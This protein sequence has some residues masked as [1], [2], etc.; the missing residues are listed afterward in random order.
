VAPVALVFAVLG[1][2]VFGLASPGEAAGVGALGALLPAGLR[3][4]L[5]LKILREML[6]MAL[7]IRRFE[8]RPREMLLAGEIR[9]TAHSSIGQEATAVGARRALEPRDLLLAHHRGHGHTLTRG[10]EPERMFAELPGRATGCCGGLG[11]SMHIADLSRNILGANGIVS[12]GTGMGTGAAPAAQL[13]GDGS[14]EVAFFGDG[15]ANEGIFHEAM[16]LAAIWRLPLILFCENNR[17][18]LSTASDAVTAGPGVARR[19]AGYG[20]PVHRTDGDDAEADFAATARAALRARA[21]EGLSLFE[22]MTYRRDDHSMRANLPRDRSPD[23]EAVHRAGDPILRRR[24]TSSPRPPRPPMAS[25]CSPVPRRSPR[26]WRRR[27]P[28]TPP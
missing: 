18:G 12:A 4:S 11:G 9:G 7:L 26:R 20:V 25:A 28:A 24:A 21:G 23:A 17:Y 19:A 15:A 2:I 8:T 16:N 14:V 27:W 10:A 6:H 5:S 1:S 13:R 22:A 3:G